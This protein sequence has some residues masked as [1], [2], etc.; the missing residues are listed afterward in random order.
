M[1]SPHTEGNND[2]DTEQ[3]VSKNDSLQRPR[4]LSEHEGMFTIH[5]NL[6]VLFLKN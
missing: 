6:L 4:Q 3:D 1:I 5:I 2:D